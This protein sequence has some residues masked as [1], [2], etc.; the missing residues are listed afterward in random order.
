L[1]ISIQSTGG[2][3]VSAEVHSCCC[4]LSNRLTCIPFASGFLGSLR[5]GPP[6]EGPR[7]RLGFPACRVPAVGT[8]WLEGLNR[9]LVRRMVQHTKHSVV[10]GPLVS[11]FTY[12]HYSQ[13]PQIAAHRVCRRL[14]IAVGF[15]P[16]WIV[17]LV[18]HPRYFHVLPEHRALMTFLR[19]LQRATR[20]TAHAAVERASGAERSRLGQR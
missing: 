11:V 14:T 13:S 16:R 12:S 4:T 2:L 1:G 17:V 10:I 5:R 20:T 6:C 18:V 8:P 7:Q 9:Q 3:Y 19:A 15:S